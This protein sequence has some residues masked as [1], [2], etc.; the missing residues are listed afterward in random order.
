MRPGPGEGRGATYGGD[1][2]YLRRNMLVNKSCIPTKLDM[3]VVGLRWVIGTVTAT[4]WN[5][6][7]SRSGNVTS[8]V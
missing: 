8:L 6:E 7:S 3:V 1:A 5:E 4:I 2:M